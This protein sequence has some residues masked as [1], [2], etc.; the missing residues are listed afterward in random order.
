[1][2]FFEQLSKIA[3]TVNDAA[4]FVQ[5]I[6]SGALGNDIANK[7]INSVLKQQTVDKPAEPEDSATVV[8]LNPSVENKVPVCYGTAFTKGVIVDA[9]LDADEKSLWISFVLSEATGEKIDGTQSITLLEEVYL[10]GYPATF[11][12]DGVHIADKRD[13][14]GNI[15]SS[16]FDLIEV[17]FYSNGTEN[18]TF[19]TGYTGTA[20]DAYDL[21]PGWGGGHVYGNLVFAIVKVT[22]DQENGVTSIPEFTFKIKNSMD[23]PG[24]VLYDYLT[25]K[26][27][28]AGIPEE[29]IN[30]V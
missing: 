25:N 13:S 10:D 24:D 28:G 20:Q 9:K 18:Q 14:Q 21:F 30:K 23:D 19:P 29:E 22:H 27:Y 12:S 15:D 8:T 26:R 7:V 16:V 5:G 4:T 2:S 1:M 6:K 11:Q 17:Y 3:E